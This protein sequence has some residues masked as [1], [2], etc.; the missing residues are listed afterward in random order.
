MIFTVD[1]RSVIPYIL[2]LL[3]IVGLIGCGGG[4][5]SAPL[6]P[7]A[8]PTGYYTGSASV[9]EPAD[10]NVDYPISD[11]QIMISGTRIMMMSNLTSVLYDG[12][13]TVSGNDL[14]SIMTV[15]YNGD[16]QATTATLN[17]RITEESQITGTF[18]GINLGNGTFVS[19]FSNL[20]NAAP[21]FNNLNFDPGASFWGPETSLNLDSGIIE[22]E[23][24]NSNGDFIGSDNTTALKF[25]NCSPDTGST[26]SQIANTSFFAVTMNLTS[27]L[28]NGGDTNSAVTGIYTGFAQMKPDGSGNALAFSVS[29]GTYSIVDDYVEN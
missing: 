20:S 18:T 29:N 4:G 14:T 24:T 17:A 27:C 7:D 25:D 12:M 10:N 3:M 1:K 16:K 8:N 23:I 2:S 11:L 15:Y 21:N 26:F 22:F 19:T 28:V 9:K 5:G 6:P 13:F